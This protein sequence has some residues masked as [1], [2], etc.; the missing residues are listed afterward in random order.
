MDFFNAKLTLR[1]HF[2]PERMASLHVSILVVYT[3]STVNEISSQLQL[4][5][6]K[7]VLQQSILF[8]TASGSATFEYMCIYLHLTA[9]KADHM[10]QYHDYANINEHV[11]RIHGHHSP[12]QLRPR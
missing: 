4:S 12:T 3:N 11:L 9:S 1:L 10:R 5:R 8:D 7:Q 2:A 6:D